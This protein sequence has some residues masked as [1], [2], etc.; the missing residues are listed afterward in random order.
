[1]PT[2]RR[3]QP[4]GPAFRGARR[5]NRDVGMIGVMRVIQSLA[6]AVLTPVNFAMHAS[7][8]DCPRSRGDA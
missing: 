5:H 6:G 2:S 8:V 1:M 3:G 4:A 7:R